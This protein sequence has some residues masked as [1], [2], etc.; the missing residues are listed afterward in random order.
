[1]PDGCLLLQAGKQLEWLTGGHITAGFHEVVISP[2]TIRVIN[3]VRS[4]ALYRHKAQ[5]TGTHVLTLSQQRSAKNLPLWRISSTVFG[6]IASDQV[7][8]P[9][10]KY[11]TAEATAQYPPT[12]AGAQVND[13]L[14]KI[15]LAP[16]SAQPNSA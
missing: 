6:H 5:P 3:E 10:G 1:M 12:K 14:A 13:E 16:A 2:E 8:T 7:L 9:L 11:A 4:S 15:A